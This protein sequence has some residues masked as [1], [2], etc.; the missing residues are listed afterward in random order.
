MTSTAANATPTFRVPLSLRLPFRLERAELLKLRTRRG[1]AIP[2]VLLTVG[3]MLVMYLVLE[4]FHLSNS[5]KY[6]PAGGTSN[7]SHAV[8]MLG[9]LAG[10]IGAALVGAAAGT[11]DL[12][13]GVFRE[14][15]ATGRSRARL[16]LARIPGGLA[17]LLPLVAAAYAIVAVLT[18]ALAGGNSTPTVGGFAKEGLWV[19]L[20]AGV[21]YMVALGLGSLVGSRAATISILLAY[22][23]PVQAILRSISALGRSRDALVSAAI[24][25]VSPLTV[26]GDRANMVHMSVGAAALSMSLWVAIALGLGM[27]RTQTRDA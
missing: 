16:F 22:L 4:L 14:L 27:W 17:L 19:L 13:A 1:V 3:A 15:V 21:I 10:M 26:G 18:V 8:F 5:A 6:G 7:F 11:E 12:G 24:D 23:L 20:S 25:R 2:T 9:Q